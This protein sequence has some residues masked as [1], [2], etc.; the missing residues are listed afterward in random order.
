MAAMAAMGA[1][2]V[3]RCSQVYKAMRRHVQECAV[4]I[5]RNV[6][7]DELT[8]FQRV[9]RLVL[10]LLHIC[11][12]VL[13][14]PPPS[15]QQ[16]QR[17]T[18]IPAL[19]L[20]VCY[21]TSSDQ[22]R[23]ERVVSG[24]RRCT[25]CSS[26]ASTATSSS[27]MV[28]SASR[29]KVC[30]LSPWNTVAHNDIIRAILRHIAHVHRLCLLMISCAA[31]VWLMDCR[32]LRQPSHAGAG[33]HGG[34][35]PV[36]SAEGPPPRGA[37]V[38]WPGPQPCPGHCPGPALPS[39]AQ[40]KSFHCF[41]PT[42]HMFDIDRVNTIETAHTLQAAAGAW[43]VQRHTSGA[44]GGKEASKRDNSNTWTGCWDCMMTPMCCCRWCMRT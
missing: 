38:V 31:T 4:K 23:A 35:G 26:A 36:V 29:S 43:K 5:L 40:G 33:V 12:I 13:F 41:H 42:C 2:L 7:E 27:S 19:G 24:R 22:A 8:N 44:G 6:N 32:L 30:Q 15:A 9:G 17:L 10:A 3:R 25:S 34:G 1:K 39:R 37:A 21:Q 18:R 28:R 14:S 16:C 11:M 20:P